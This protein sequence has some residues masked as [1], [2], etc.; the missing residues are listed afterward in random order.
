MKESCDI[1]CA[2]RT[3]APE[4][5]ARYAGLRDDIFRELIRTV[6]LPDGYAFELR[7]GA[8]VRNALAEW[9]PLELQC[10]PFLDIAVEPEAGPA[11]TETTAAETTNANGV[12]VLRMTGPEAVKSF[13]LHELELA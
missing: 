6:E 13:L 11:G 10:C 3:F 7:E 8:E 5:H 1:A 9:V 12:V 4:Q 2:R